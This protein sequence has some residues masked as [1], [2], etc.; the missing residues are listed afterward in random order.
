MGRATTL[1]VAS[2]GGHLTQLRLLVP[3]IRP[4]VRAATWTSYDCLTARSALSGE[5]MVPGNGPSTRHL[6]NAARNYQ[7][8][9]RILSGGH[10]DRVVSTGAGIAVRFLVEASRRGLEGHY[11]ESASR[12][13]GPSLSGRLLMRLAPEVHLYTQHAR[14]ADRRWQY[15]GS[16]FE[17]YSPLQPRTSIPRSLRVLVTLGTHDAYRFDTLLDRVA[18]LMLRDD[19]IVWQTGAT[20]GRADLPG[21]TEHAIP[22]AEMHELVAWADVVVAHCGTGTILTALE[23]GKHPVVVP[24]RHARGEHVDDHQA[25]TAREVSRLGLARWV[26]ADQL[27]R[28]DLLDAASSSCGRES[29][30]PFFLS[31]GQPRNGASQ[32]DIVQLPEAVLW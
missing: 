19:D 1:L 3:R 11:I 18:A 25:V 6:G 20:T 2:D 29:A 28:R 15:A 12:V 26:E 24:R 4:E 32:E 27:S 17:G 8:A 7:L 10:F 22:A 23:H 9:R 14:W 13:E 16:V 31:G 21:R 30:L 5:H